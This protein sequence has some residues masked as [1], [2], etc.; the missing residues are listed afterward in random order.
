MK[1]RP[2]TFLLALVLT[3][4]STGCFGMF[5]SRG[6]EESAVI[7]V[8]NDLDPPDAMTIQ[9]RRTG[10]DETTLGTVPAG[11]ER[12]LT[13]KSRDL[14]GAYQLVARQTSG[15]A[16]VSREFTLF[17]GARVRWEMRTNSVA[18]SER[19]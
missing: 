14:Q 4:L 5:G 10:G 6:P 7:T 2:F 17:V 18:V 12:A 11:G 8:R 1:L 13:Y 16:V 3:T 9:I 19:P 15:A